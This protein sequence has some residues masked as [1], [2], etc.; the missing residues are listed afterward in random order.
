MVVSSFTNW[1]LFPGLGE[2]DEEPEF[3]APLDDEPPVSDDE[4][5]LEEPDEELELEAE[6]PDEELVFELA[7]D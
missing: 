3:E 4:P 5:E 7:V 2:P 1:A 6:A